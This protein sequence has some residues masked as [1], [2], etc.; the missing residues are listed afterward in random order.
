[1]IDY[2]PRGWKN[3]LFDIYGS[4]AHQILSRVLSCA[5]FSAVVVGVHTFCQTH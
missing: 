5:L 4:M 3:H 2:D 1:M